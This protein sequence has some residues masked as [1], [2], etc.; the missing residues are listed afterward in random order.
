MESHF[1]KR[2]KLNRN[3]VHLTFLPKPDRSKHLLW[4]KNVR[5]SALDYVRISKLPIES[6][7]EKYFLIRSDDN[8]R[9]CFVYVDD[10]ESSPLAQFL[11]HR[12]TQLS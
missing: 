4:I 1:P 12:S 6:E 11:R 2:G 3:V 10:G 5:L 8:I 7:G 9:A